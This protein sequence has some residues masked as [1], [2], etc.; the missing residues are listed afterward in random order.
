MNRRQSQ[1]LVA[2]SGSHLECLSVPCR[3]QSQPCL[4]DA[5]R[6]HGGMNTG[7]LVNG[8]YIDAAMYR[9]RH[10]APKPFLLLRVL[11]NVIEK[12]LTLGRLLPR[13]L[14]VLVLVL[15]GKL[16]DR[17]CVCECVCGKTNGAPFCFVCTTKRSYSRETANGANL[18]DMLRV[19]DPAMSLQVSCTIIT[20]HATMLRHSKTTVKALMVSDMV[21]QL[22]APSNPILV[23]GQQSPA[24]PNF[25]PTPFQGGH[26]TPKAPCQKW[27]WLLR[28]FGGSS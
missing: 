13:L 28:R 25:P 11:H 10:C 21:I 1:R 16:C 3:A 4:F 14:L 7:C 18:P 5:S 27:S 15:M 2:S 12:V 24:N 19:A 26:Q 6:R 8:R 9:S 23:D 22:T 20:E 17:V